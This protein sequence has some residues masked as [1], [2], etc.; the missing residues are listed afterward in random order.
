MNRVR[1]G[2]P[3]FQLVMA[4]KKFTSKTLTTLQYISNISIL[5]TTKIPSMPCIRVSTM[6]VKPNVSIGTLFQELSAC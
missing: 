4:A 1:G 5:T 2:A 3:A 6:K